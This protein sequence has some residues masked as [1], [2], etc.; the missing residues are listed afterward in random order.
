MEKT[1]TEKRMKQW[2]GRLQLALWVLLILLQMAVVQSLEVRAAQT[3]RTPSGWEESGQ[4]GDESGG[5]WQAGSSGRVIEQEAVYRQVEALSEV[6][7]VMEAEV[8]AGG[9]GETVLCHAAASEVIGEQWLEDFSFP[10]T[11]H[12]YGADHYQLGGI[13][14]PSGKELQAEAWAGEL[15]ELIGVPADSYEISGLFWSGEPYLD[16]DGV[17]CRDAEAFGR[18]LVRDIR[19]EYRGMAGTGAE[20][21]TMQRETAAAREELSEAETGQEPQTGVQ[22]ETAGE[23]QPAEAE[24][25]GQPAGWDMLSFLRKLTRITL[26]AVGIGVLLCAAGLLLLLALRVIRFFRRKGQLRKR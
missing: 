25:D 15:L 4:A 19:V 20:P 26:I 10:V 18:R 7:E 22:P 16:A 21:E 2:T 17:L 23:R 9:T 12:G 6:P 13:L 5:S 3:P 8:T 24:K 14:V 11:F 1:K